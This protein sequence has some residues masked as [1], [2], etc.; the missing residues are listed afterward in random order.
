M[1][2]EA[3][4]GTTPGARS[5]VTYQTEQSITVIEQTAE[6]DTKSS[7]AEQAEKYQWPLDSLR[8]SQSTTSQFLE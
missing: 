2:V 6:K 5:V 3:V 4:E 1:C 7:A 8:N